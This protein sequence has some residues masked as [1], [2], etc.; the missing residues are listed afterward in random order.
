MSDRSRAELVVRAELGFPGFRLEVDET[1]GLSGVLGLFGPSGSGKS[2]LLRIIAGLEPA[3]DARVR[4][5]GS[6]WQ[7]TAT[8][9][10]VP[11]WR[12]PVG[13]VFQ[14]ARLF[15]HLDV[16]GNLAYAERRAEKSAPAVGFDEV[17]SALNLSG[18]LARRTGSLSGGE[19]QRVAIARTLLTRPRL[20]LFDEPLAALDAGHKREILPYLEGLAGRFGIPAI[21][22]SHA[23]GEMARLADDVVVLDAGKVV[24][25]GHA[26][27]ILAHVDDSL[28]LPGFEAISVLGATVTEHLSEMH[29]SRVTCR[30]QQLTVPMID[31]ANPGDPVR[32][33][34]RAGD[35]VLATTRPENLSVRNV[36]RGRVAEISPG[37]GSAFAL[38]TVDIDGTPLRAQLTRHSIGELGLAQGM[39][40]YALVKTATFD[41]GL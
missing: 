41:R 1:L 40:V 7:D 16:A 12:R 21:Y 25:V 22:V 32:L 30:D 18:L 14:D 38:V 3:A 24:R 31:N 29:L 2:T 19:R 9:S 5:S 23:A 17:V 13:F 26:A 36:L 37:A 34:I 4:F 27:D 39:T 10:F 35:V 33:A 8:R 6:L 11:A 28:T 15:E 20:M